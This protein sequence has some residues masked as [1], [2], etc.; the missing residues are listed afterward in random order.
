[1]VGNQ[2]WSVDSLYSLV[3]CMG[4]YWRL[5]TPGAGR[6][7]SGIARPKHAKLDSA[8]EY[9]S[10]GFSKKGIKKE[11]ETNHDSCSR[12]SSLPSSRQSLSHTNVRELSEVDFT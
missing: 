6:T 1:M 11:E 8:S 7:G 10:K 3:L 2:I 12:S 4:S 9:K 5:P